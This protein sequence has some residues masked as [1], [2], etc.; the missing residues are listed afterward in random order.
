MP[1]MAELSSPDE[2]SWLAR[3]Q[4]PSSSSSILSAGLSR[5]RFLTLS[6]ATVGVA[7]AGYLLAACGSG[8]SGGTAATKKSDTLTVGVYQEPDSLD[9]GATGLVVAEFMLDGIFD[10]LVWWLPTPG[11]G[12]QYYPGLAT[13][14]EVSPDG[15]AYTFKLRQDV[16]F[17]DGTH[18]DAN[19]VK[20]TFDHIVN[21]ATKSRSAIGSLGPY[22]ETK[23]IDQYT[24]QVV[25]SSPNA[26]FVHEM[27]T[28]LFNMVS[29]A[30][31][32]KYGHAGL[33]AHPVGTGPFTFQEY[34]T[35][36]HMTV[37][38]NPKYKWGPTAF[39]P[40]GPPK[41]KTI[42]YKILTD[43]T[44]RF[45]ALQTGQL[46]LAMNLNPNDIKTVKSTSGLTHYNLPSTGQ[47]YGYPINVTKGPTDDLKVRQA[48]NFA[49]DQDTLNKTVLQG[50]YEA[51]HNV[52]TPTTPGYNK[53]DD[54]MYAFNPTKAKS[55]LDSAGWTASGNATRTKNGQPLE[56]EILIQSANGFDLPTQ[57]V[58][59]QL[60]AVGIAAKTTS[61]P[62]V[63]AA[64]SYNQGV[65][66]LSAI[67]YYDVDP[68]LLNNL[69]NSANIKAGFNWA[70]YTD[71][72]VDS[73]ILKA[74]GTVD[75]AARTELWQQITHTLMEA[76]IFLPLWNVSGV[77]SAASNLKDMHFGVTG[78]P[79]FHTAALT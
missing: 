39:G 43:P 36:D 60:K 2:S 42:T 48:I 57:F 23:V 32:K 78:Y 74:N 66:N 25:F 76:A 46:Q 77:F 12:K 26:A 9:P 49:V 15:T 37:V 45:N 53:A 7:G 35:Q 30:A 27:T 29:P 21:P 56:L 19:A 64:A 22:K 10:P 34:V 1:D 73:G 62:F 40:S 11:G 18:F 13:S 5:R 44:A 38:A 58:V 50:A 61:Q 54:T 72:T 28:N 71:P 33:A 52:L 20:A 75:E 41:L 59:S 31:I 17:H 4:S 16:E 8:S 63:T 51:A 6:G 68:Y 70:H 65:Q 3:A 47:P 69:V 55:L 67:F 24:A 79:F 14:Y